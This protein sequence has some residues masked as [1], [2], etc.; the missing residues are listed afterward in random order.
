MSQT[1]V[2]KIGGVAS[3][4]LGPEFLNQLKFWKEDGHR[5]I[6]VHGGGFAI[7]K[8]MKDKEV[9][10]KKINGIRVTSQSDMPLVHHALLEQVGLEISRKCLQVGLDCIQLKAN[11]PKVIE[12]E[13][14][15][16]EIYGYV[17]QVSQINTDILASI[18]DDD[19]IPILASLGYSKSYEE[20]NINA[21]YLATAVA[22]ALR[23]DRLILLTDVPG[24]LENQQ[25]LPRL[26]VGDIQEKIDLGVISSGMIPKI[27]AAA[28]TVLAGVGQVMIGNN[29]NSGTIIE[30]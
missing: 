13:Y 29:L 30:E 9:P 20:L 26:K 4:Q 2:I 25:V 14:L 7:T 1:I 10:V 12:A 11:L 23:V 3:Q 17:G 15:D 21:D 16:K 19:F 27:E 24:V 28:Q 18:L 6:I 22:I 5:L 8:L